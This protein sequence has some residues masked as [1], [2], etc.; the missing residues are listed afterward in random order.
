[1][2]TKEFNN[3]QEFQDFLTRITTP[4]IVTT[5]ITPKIT[6]KILTL[7]TCAF[8]FS[9]ARLAVHALLVKTKENKK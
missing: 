5:N 6:D 1:Y 9:D 3:D 4:S 8:D 7:S 2:R